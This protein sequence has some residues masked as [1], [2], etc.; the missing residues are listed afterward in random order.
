MASSGKSK[1]A[2]NRP[3][4]RSCTRPVLF[5]CLGWR[6]DPRDAVVFGV[7]VCDVRRPILWDDPGCRLCFVLAMEGPLLRL[8][9]RQCL[10]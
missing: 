6:F 10:H 9:L 3:E 5:L 7:D 2:C 1:E 4:S 8:S